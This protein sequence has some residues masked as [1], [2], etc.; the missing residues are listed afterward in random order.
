MAST[1]ITSKYGPVLR[2]SGAAKEGGN[3]ALK[4]KSDK[5]RP[6]GRENPLSQRPIYMRGGLLSRARGSAYLE[7]GG[8][9][10][11]C[12]V[13]GP[14]ASPSSVEGSVVCDLRWAAFARAQG[15]SARDD[16]AR[17]S[18]RDGATDLERELSSALA[19]TLSAAVRL[20]AYPKARIDVSAFVLED[21]GAAFAACVSA[22][23]AA[24]ADAGIECRDLV[25]AST[26][27][28]VDGRVVLDPCAAEEDAA[29]GTVLLAYM[30]TFAAV[31]DVI[32]T[33]EMEPDVVVDALRLC[34]ESATQ[35][36]GLL[37]MELRKQAGKALRQ[38]ANRTA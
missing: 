12:A 35:I 21:D 4:K 37:R 29:D 25:C 27:A 19:R 38:R 30:P 7:A 31:T 34:S 1:A 11:F 28:L 17:T 6:D 10:V 3:A 26:A 36:C 9:K 14:R 22:A 23:A 5:V 15:R 16:S 18:S 24:L 32:Q 33:G 20:E 8:T 2:V 13:N